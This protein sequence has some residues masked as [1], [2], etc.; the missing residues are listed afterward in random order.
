MVK[1]KSKTS[2][3]ASEQGGRGNSERYG[4]EACL[5]KNAIIQSSSPFLFLLCHLMNI[6]AEDCELFM[7]KHSV[8]H[9]K[10]FE[11][12]N[13]VEIVENGLNYTPES[14]IARIDKM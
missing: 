11:N 2:E 8:M 10:F 3:L 1:V 9:I 12:L 4:K 5:R 6:Y 13:R 7:H 14:Y